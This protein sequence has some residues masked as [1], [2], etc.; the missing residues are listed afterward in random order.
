MK[1]N[2]D[3]VYRDDYRNTGTYVFIKLFAG[4]SLLERLL[5]VEEP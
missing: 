1:V 5:D 3:T 2:L 4:I